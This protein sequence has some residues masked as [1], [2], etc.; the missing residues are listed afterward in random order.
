M[1]VCICI[2]YIMCIYIHVY[3]HCNVYFMSPVPSTVEKLHYS[4]AIA[5]IKFI[6]W[7][8]STRHMWVRKK[9]PSKGVQRGGWG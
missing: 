9:A 1:Y 6:L 7:A 2:Y 8:L 3:L 4:L 5:R